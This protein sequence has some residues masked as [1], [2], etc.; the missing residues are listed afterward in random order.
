MGELYEIKNPLYLLSWLTSIKGEM[1]IL[2]LSIWFHFSTRNHCKLSGMYCRLITCLEQ[3]IRLEPFVYQ[4]HMHDAW[5]GRGG[6]YFI[7]L[8]KELI[9]ATFHLL[10]F[11][12]R[13]DSSSESFDYAD[14][15]RVI[16]LRLCLYY[17]VDAIAL[18]LNRWGKLTA[19][20]LRCSR[21]PYCLVLILCSHLLEGL[22][23]TKKLVCYPPSTL[24][25]S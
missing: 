5:W 1:L 14:Y 13:L 2:H 9:I 17:L 16:D 6:I 25:I 24:S 15:L 20:R 11:I 7:R 8:I 12:T 23:A 3:W 10:V 18:V 4:R 22:V 21:T 19:C